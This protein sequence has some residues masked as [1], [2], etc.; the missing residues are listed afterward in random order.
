MT[1]T[2]YYKIIKENA[3]A[4][5]NGLISVEEFLNKMVELAVQLKKE[6]MLNL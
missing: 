1:E 3:Y 2:E 5:E 4:L 6:S